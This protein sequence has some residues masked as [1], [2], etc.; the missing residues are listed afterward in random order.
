MSY[1]ED[2]MEAWEE[3]G[4]PGDPS[5]IDSDDMLEAHFQR[6]RRENQQHAARHGFPSITQYQKAEQMAW[7]KVYG[8]S[9]NKW[10]KSGKPAPLPGKGMKAELKRLRREANERQKIQI[11]AG[12]D[13]DRPTILI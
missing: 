11:I 7:V 12:S 9:K 1:F 3:L 6:E 8:M 5:D 2:Q 4:C 13:P 10:K